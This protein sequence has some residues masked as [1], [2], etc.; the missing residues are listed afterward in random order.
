MRQT[1]PHWVCQQCGQPINQGDGYI[2]AINVDSGVAPVGAYP[3]EPSLEVETER[4][5]HGGVTMD[6]AVWAI[7]Q[8]RIRVG[9]IVY[10]EEHDP[11]PDNEGLHDRCGAR[12][13][14]GGVGRVGATSP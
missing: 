4:G 8:S 1:E 3:Q 6:A 14:P 11:H 13:D 9:F 5:E 2:E 7:R 12:T 10:H